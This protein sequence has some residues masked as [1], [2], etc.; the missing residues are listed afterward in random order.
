[1]SLT[2]YIIAN[3]KRYPKK[4][5]YSCEGVSITYEDLYYKVATLSKNLKKMRL[6]K[7]D[8]IA[9]IYGNSII[10]PQI[11]YSAAY[12]DLSIVPLNP[13]LSKGD[14]INQINKLNIKILFSWKE[15][16]NNLDFKKLK[17]KK[18]NCFDL[19]SSSKSY[20]NYFD[21]VKG[22]NKKFFLKRK[23]LKSNFDFLYGL[24][25]GSTSDP[26][27]SIWSQ[28]VKIE[29]GKHAKKIYNLKH[30]EKIIISTPMYHSISFRLIVLPVILGAT[31]IILKKFTTKGWFENIQKW[32]VS[33]SILVSDQVEMVS[34]QFKKQNMKKIRSLKKLVSCCSPLKHEIKERLVKQSNFEIFDTYGASEVG[35]ITNINLKKEQKKI[36]SNGKVTLGYNVSILKNSKLTNVPFTNGEICCH[37]KNIFTGY[38]GLMDKQ[39]SNKALN[40]FFQ[41]GDIG[42]FDKE[43]Y[44]YVTGRKKDIIIRGGVNIFP[45]DIEQI[46]NRFPNIIESAVIGVEVK[47]LGETIYAFIRLKRNKQINSKIFYKY[48]F[49]NFADFQFPSKFFIVKEFPRA[50]LN[51]ISKY[52]LK[53]NISKYANNRNL[54]K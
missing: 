4:I 26:K 47:N 17:L 23:N 21:L 8:K 34:S 25:S 2:N 44:L 43:N 54:I 31:C 29:R 24:T 41:T 53:K 40:K 10:Y 11:F 35:T 12:L 39:K 20:R 13:S 28:H 33:F 22:N 19:E 52:L 5:A 30:T 18:I 3:K 1:M 37:T 27:V 38:F 7:G 6:K 32:K 46:L 42:Y 51:K 16:L 15:F 49:K 36:K 9:I 48:C 14:L 45:S 50:S